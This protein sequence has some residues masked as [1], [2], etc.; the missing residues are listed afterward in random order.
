MR[1]HRNRKTPAK[2]VAGLAVV[3]SSGPW[4]ACSGGATKFM[5][6][7]P[8][9]IQLAHY[10]PASS[11][12]HEPG[13]LTNRSSMRTFT[14]M[15][16]TLDLATTKRTR[17]MSDMVCLHCNFASGHQ[18]LS[19]SCNISEAVVHSKQ[20]TDQVSALAPTEARNP[21]SSLVA[22]QPCQNHHN[23]HNVHIHSTQRY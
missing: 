2:V 14:C 16:I 1:S 10:S 23:D 7:P 20:Y 12:R 9:P 4:I 15:H 18:I 5:T 21:H 22:Q 11:S 8:P 13:N 3:C 17:N 6:P 19:N